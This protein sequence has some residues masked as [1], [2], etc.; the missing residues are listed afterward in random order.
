M[1]LMRLIE[2]YRSI[3]E[4]E[5]KLLSVIKKELMEMRAKYASPRRTQLIAAEGEF[6]AFSARRKR[7][8]E[9]QKKDK[10]NIFFYVVALLFW[11]NRKISHN[12]ILLR[13]EKKYRIC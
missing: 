9:R 3:L 12:N 13:L 4:S 10:K 8:R 7:Y 6:R 1:E 2:E 5:K 11:F